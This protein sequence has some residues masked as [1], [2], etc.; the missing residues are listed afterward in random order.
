MAT[1]HVLSHS[2]F[3]DSRFESCLRILGQ[4]DG[5]LLSGD[6]VYALQAGTQAAEQLET[7][8]ASTQLYALDEDV[9]ARNITAHSA[10]K[11]VGYNVFVALSCQFDKVNSWI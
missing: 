7:A 8:S 1:L 11:I 5:L 3:T 9:L 2:P 4:N 6:A 10:V